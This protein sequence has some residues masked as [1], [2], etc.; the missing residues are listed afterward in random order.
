MLMN[1][2]TNAIKFTTFRGKIKVTARILRSDT[3]LAIRE[4][5]FVN[6]MA[7]AKGKRYL[8]VQVEDT[9]VGIKTED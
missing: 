2:I 8:E 1:L 3:D 7:K 9:G 4:V 5:S 6:I